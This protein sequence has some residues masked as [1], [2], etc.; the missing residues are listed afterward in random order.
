MARNLGI[1]E[2]LRFAENPGYLRSYADF[3]V[4]MKEILGAMR[5]FL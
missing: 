1:L 3:G 2:L 5:L 4:T